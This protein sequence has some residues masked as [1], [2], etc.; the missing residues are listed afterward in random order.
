MDQWP[1]WSYPIPHGPTP[2]LT[3]VCLVPLTERASAYDLGDYHHKIWTSSPEAQTLFD[4]GMI[5]TFGFNREESIR[6][7]QSAIDLDPNAPMPRWGLAYALGPDLNKAAVEPAADPSDYPSFSQAGG[8][9]DGGV[10]IDRL[11]RPAGDTTI[12]S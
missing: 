7:F 10:N 2:S 4:Q 5:L 3:F 9:H 11:G 6:A 12:S 1:C 8:S